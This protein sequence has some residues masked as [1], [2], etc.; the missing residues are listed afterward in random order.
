LRSWSWRPGSPP[1]GSDCRGE[2]PLL[3]TVRWKILSPEAVTRKQLVLSC[4]EWTP[5]RADHLHAGQARREEVLSGRSFGLWNIDSS[6][7]FSA[8]FRD[9]V[10]ARRGT[11]TGSRG[12]RSGAG[13]ARAAASRLRRASASARRLGLLPESS[14]S[15]ELLPPLTVARF[16]PAERSSIRARAGP[17]RGRLPARPAARCAAPAYPC[18]RRGVYSTVSPESTASCA[19]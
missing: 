18:T 12:P 2:H 7:A 9:A 13:R 11:I 15:L 16:L 17:P 19:P 1:P 8:G 10:G 4:Q 3:E 6:G 14:R 5:R